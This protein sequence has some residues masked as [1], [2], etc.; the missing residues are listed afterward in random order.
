M[1]RCSRGDRVRL[2]RG[3]GRAGKCRR[4]CEPRWGAT[5]SRSRSLPSGLC[6]CRQLAPQ[7]CPY[8]TPR[9]SASQL[10]RAWLCLLVP[11]HPG[12]LAAAGTEQD[13]PTWGLGQPLIFPFL[14][15]AGSARTTLS[16]RIATSWFETGHP[17]PTPIRCLRPS[18]LTQWAGVSGKVRVGQRV[19]AR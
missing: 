11:P 4:Y 15:L 10:P 18:G 13:Q 17:L 16:Q 5:S 9:V 1:G 8:P 19:P 7:G 3:S 12:A 2:Q 6:V 14:L